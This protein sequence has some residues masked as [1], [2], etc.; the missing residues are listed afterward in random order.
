MRH[1]IGCVIELLSAQ[2]LY[3]LLKVTALHGCCL[4]S[5]GCL[6]LKSNRDHVVMPCRSGLIMVRNN[7][8]LPCHDANTGF[9][10]LQAGGAA[11][12]T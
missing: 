6:F 5:D 8:L 10:L 3:M 2:I 12:S 1:H 9:V 11:I 4:L 7:A